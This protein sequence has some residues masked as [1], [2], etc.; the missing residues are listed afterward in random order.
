MRRVALAVLA[1]S[2]I[3]TSPSIAAAQP[4]PTGSVKFFLNGAHVVSGDVNGDGVA[5]V[6]VGAGAG[7]PGGHVRV[8]D[9]LTS[10]L[11]A[12]FDAFPRFTGGV[13]VAAGDL[14]GDRLVDVIAG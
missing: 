3:S 13:Y 2:L 10:G 14:D 1:L 7:A 8:F 5:D 6:I 4:V 11:L 12:S 9:G